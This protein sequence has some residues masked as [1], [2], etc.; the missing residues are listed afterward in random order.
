MRIQNL[1]LIAVAL[2]TYRVV[3]EED[4][5]PHLT[6][7]H[8]F[9]ES[10]LLAGVTS[11]A[12]LSF[13]VNLTEVDQELQ[14]ADYLAKKFKEMKKNTEDEDALRII[15]LYE[16]VLMRRVRQ[17]KRE[18]SNL[19]NIFTHPE[20]VLAEGGRR[21]RRF[22]VATAAVVSTLL[23]VLNLQ[24]LLHLSNSIE[25]EDS[26]YIVN[27]LQDHEL[28]VSL[29]EQKVL[30]I[31]GTVEKIKKVLQKNVLLT[32][33]EAL[34]VQIEMY[35]D[36]IAFEVNRYKSGL[37]GLLSG[38][39]TPDFIDSNKLVGA[40]S[41]LAIKAKQG[42]YVLPTLVQ[43]IF[44]L[45]TSFISKNN[46]VQVLIHL[47]MLRETDL[48]RLYKFI[49]LPISLNVSHQHLTL[50]QT[51]GMI[52]VTDDLSGYSLVSEEEEKDCQ[53]IS[54]VKFCPHHNVL[55]RNF[56]QFCLSAL[57]REKASVISEV[58]DFS[59]AP[60]HYEAKQ[61]G[62]TRFLLYHPIEDKVQIQCTTGIQTIKFKGSKILN[63]DPDCKGVNDKY[64]FVAERNVGLNFSYHFSTV[65]TST[66]QIFEGFEVDKLDF[67]VQNKPIKVRDIVSEYRARHRASA[68]FFGR[69]GA[70]AAS[71]CILVILGVLVFLIV[72]T[73]LRGRQKKP[74]QAV[75]LNVHQPPAVQPAPPAHLGDDG[76]PA[77]P[78]E[79]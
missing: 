6:Q 46:V 67:R 60:A 11:W 15:R 47:P 7:S 59:V 18:W 30:K 27:V 78:W 25:A 50:D 70:G 31:N 62:P 75:E 34:S 2:V 49:P 29:L 16:G 61:L 45:P 39:I 4:P 56:N 8:L 21:V 51:G 17:I 53:T 35:L 40:L 32:H 24:E 52:A 71:L 76:Q 36:V 63:L 12:H 22:I 68:G 43:H 3:A 42:G 57:F 66:K 20:Q 5:G 58:C 9:Q 65:S 37:S 74:V 28:R 41:R 73:C 33:V 55:Y 48:L 23:G 79:L 69:L 10:G 64:S 72:R 44:Q 19:R 26:E 77:Q 54:N 1:V 13:T 38:K 14:I